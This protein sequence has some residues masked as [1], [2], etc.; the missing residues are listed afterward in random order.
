MRS[1]NASSRRLS[2]IL[3]RHRSCASALVF[4]L[5]PRMTPDDIRITAHD[6][7]YVS[8]TQYCNC[9]ILSHVL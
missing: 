8:S 3:A 2:I 4:D 7:I 5:G 1:T 6:H 9:K